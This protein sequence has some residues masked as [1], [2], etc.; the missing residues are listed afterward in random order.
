MAPTLATIIESIETKI[1]QMPASKNTYKVIL[2]LMGTSKYNEWE[3]HTHPS[4]ET[5]ANNEREAAARQQQQED[6]NKKREDAARRQLG[7]QAKKDREEAA[8]R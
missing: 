4:M 1:A 3:H 7:E 5:Q 8:L 6:E 2:R